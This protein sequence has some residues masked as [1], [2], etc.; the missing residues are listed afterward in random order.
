MS[1]EELALLVAA[2]PVFKLADLDDDGTV[3]VRAH[4]LRD[5]LLLAAGLPMSA[6]PGLNDDEE[7]EA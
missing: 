1:V 7:A 3:E 4:N 5:A 2:C 6:W